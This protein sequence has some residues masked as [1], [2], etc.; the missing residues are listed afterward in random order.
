MGGDFWGANAAALKKADLRFVQSILLD[1][2]PPAHPRLPDFLRRYRARYG[3]AASDP[4]PSPVGTVHAY[5][6]TMLAA[7]AVAQA[8]RNDHEAIRAALENLPSY[9]GLMQSYRQPFT[10]ASHEALAH[11]RLH[12]ARFDAAGRI[13]A[14]E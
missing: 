5:D 10:P 3:L 6:A 13:V 1:D 14:A 9:N 7:K 11:A 4:V 2:G 12:L 8:G